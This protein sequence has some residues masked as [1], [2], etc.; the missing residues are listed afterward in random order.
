MIKNK[1]CGWIYEHT[2]VTEVTVQP[3][4]NII[5][6]RRRELNE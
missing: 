1:N 5:L 2:S 3:H 6:N 4:I